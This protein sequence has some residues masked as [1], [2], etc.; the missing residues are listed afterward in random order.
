M[1]ALLLLSVFALT[2]CDGPDS[3]D[4]GDTE[5]TDTFEPFD[6]GAPDLTEV[7]GILLGANSAGAEGIQ[8]DLCLSV[9]RTTFTDATG[10]FSVLGNPGSQHSF[11]IHGGEGFAEMLVPLAVNADFSAPQEVN[12]SLHTL[13]DNKTLSSTTSEVEIA[14]GMYVQLK[15]GDLAIDLV[16]DP[17]TEVS[18]VKVDPASSLPITLEG[19]VLAAWYLAPYDASQD[20]GT[21]V[22]F[23]N[24]YELAPGATAQLYTASYNDFDWID[25]GTVTVSEDGTRLS[26]ADVTLSR[27]TTA[28]LVVPPAR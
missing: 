7:Q 17:V 23:R 10:A 26:G 19:T 5:E 11:H 12:A 3:G 2:G 9:C 27:L 8:V 13:E 4:T 25:E 18:G 16:P 28:V 1:R 20:G 21:P 14:N 15:D 22:E 6:T 24:E